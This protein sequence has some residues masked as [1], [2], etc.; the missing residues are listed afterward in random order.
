MAVLMGL[1]FR[2]NASSGG[3]DL[4]ALIL[5]HL[6]HDIGSTIISWR[7]RSGDR[8]WQADWH[9][10]LKN[11]LYAVIAIAIST[12]LSDVIVQGL[13]HGKLVYIISSHCEEIKACIMN[14]IGR[15]VTVLNTRGGYTNEGR[16]MIISVLSSRQLVELK[17]KI[18]TIDENSFLIVGQVT[19]VF[20]E[21][22]TKFSP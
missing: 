7:D 4:M 1:M 14:E 10:D 15:G 20:G 13:R 18:R 19:E 17:D 11:M 21:G 22:F 6:R 8:L 3:V 2:Q 16:V 9:L 5:N 12:K